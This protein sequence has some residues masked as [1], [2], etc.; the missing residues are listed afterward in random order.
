MYCGERGNVLR[1]EWECTVGRVGMYC[2]VSGNVLWGEWEC[3]AGGMGMYC[4]ES[5]NPCCSADR[6]LTSRSDTH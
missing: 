2:G 3:T 6:L 4:R 1:G 5:V